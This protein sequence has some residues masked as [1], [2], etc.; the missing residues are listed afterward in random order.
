MMGMHTAA[1]EVVGGSVVAGALSVTLAAML[2]LL[3]AVPLKGTVVF[4]PGDPVSVAAASTAR[5]PG[6]WSG[7]MNLGLALHTPAS[8]RAVTSKVRVLRDCILFRFGWRMTSTTGDTIG[9]I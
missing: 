8:V 4:R 6:S 3:V 1:D 5:A 9:Q 7:R 2:S